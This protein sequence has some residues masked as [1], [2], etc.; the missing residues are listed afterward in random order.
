MTN[1]TELWYRTSCISFSPSFCT[2]WHLSLCTWKSVSNTSCFFNRPWNI[3]HYLSILHLARRHRSLSTLLLHLSAENQSYYRRV[4]INILA[5]PWLRYSERCQRAKL[6]RLGTKPSQKYLRNIYTWYWSCT[7]SFFAICQ[8]KCVPRHTR[9][10]V[11]AQ[12][13]TKIWQIVIF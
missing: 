8:H 5:A 4:I 6:S 2:S 13:H 1:T 12:K 3:K 9:S 7:S 11:P 10:P